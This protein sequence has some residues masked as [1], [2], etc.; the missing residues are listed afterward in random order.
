M[1]QRTDTTSPVDESPTWRRLNAAM[2][3]WAAWV[4]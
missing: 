4:F 2:L 3:C 1:N